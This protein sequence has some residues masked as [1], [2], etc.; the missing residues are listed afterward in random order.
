MLTRSQILKNIKLEKIN[1]NNNN[2]NKIKIDP[3]LKRDL[4]NRNF[5]TVKQLK[6][7]LKNIDEN[8]NVGVDIPGTYNE[9]N[10]ITEISQYIDEAGYFVLY[11]ENRNKFDLRETVETPTGKLGIIVEAGNLTY[12][13]LLD[14][15]EERWYNEKELKSHGYN[16]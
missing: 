12:L 7:S 3:I 10:A 6:E 14:N 15:D 8:L 2:S 5:I 9:F 16:L 4:K 13:V 11:S 1:N